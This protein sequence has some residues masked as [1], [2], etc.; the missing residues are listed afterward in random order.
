MS[1]TRCSASSF[2]VSITM[3]LLFLSCCMVSHA[4]GTLASEILEETGVK[5]GLVIHLGC[6]DGRL[7]ANLR[8]GD[9]YLV[10]GLDSNEKN[11]QQARKHIGAL[12]LYGPVSVSAFDGE[13]LPHIDNVANLVVAEDL[14]AVPMDEVLR[15]LAPL[16]V[17][18]I[19]SNGKWTKTTKP[20]PKDI[21]EWTHYLHGPDNNAVANDTVVAPPTGLQWVGG[22]LWSRAHS[23]L[24]GTSCMVSSGGRIFTIED[25]APIAFPLM[26]GKYTLVARDA[27]NG[28]VLWSR[29]LENWDNITH[30]MKPNPV[31]LPRRLVAVGGRV[32]ATLGIF[33]PVTAMDA[34][35]GE[36][37][38]VYKGTENTQEIIVQDDVL[39]VVTGDPMNPYGLAGKRTN[40]RPQYQ[41]Y[42]EKH[43]SPLRD[44]KQD[45]QFAVL[46]V[47]SKTGALLWKKTGRDSG[48]YEAM[49]LAVNDGMLVYQTKT[50]LVRLGLADGKEI[51]TKAAPTRM[52]ARS[53]IPSING[54]S[55]T[56]VLADDVI[57]RAG[58]DN[59]IAFSASDGKEMWRRPTSTT[60][61]SPPDIFVAKGIVW[62]YPSTDGYDLQTGEVAASR[63]ITRDGP[64]GH[65]RCHRNKAT[66]RYMINSRSG[67]ADFSEFDADF[68]LANPWI[69]GTCS[70]GIMPCNG[71]LY[72][73]PH[74]C[75]C[76]NE[77]KLNGFYALSDTGYDYVEENILVKGPAYKS[78]SKPGV[79]NP[80]KEWPTYRQNSARTGKAGTRLPADLEP[81]WKV[82]IPNPTAPVIASK[83]VLVANKDAHT[84]YSLNSVNGKTA[85]TFTAGGRIDSPPTNAGGRVLF[86]SADGWVYCLNA[87]T[88]ELA[89]KFRAAPNDRVTVAFG[90][91]ESLWPVH[92]SVL[93]LDDTAYVVAG[94]QSFINGGL[95]LTGIDIA[96]GSKKYETR[97][98]G[99]YGEDGESV[100]D[101][102]EGVTAES[103]VRVARQIKGNMSD[104][105]L[106]DGETIYLRHMAFTCELTPVERKEHMMTVSGFLDGSGHHRSYW[107]VAKGLIYD[108]TLGN[109]VDADLLV[110]EGQELFGTRIRRSNRSPE[111]KNGPERGYALFAMTRAEKQQAKTPP[112]KPAAKKKQT[113]KAA[114][115]ARRQ[116][117]SSYSGIWETGIPVIGKAMLKAGD[118][119]FIA[120]DPGVF[121][122]NDIFRAVEGRAGG[123]LITA[124]A[125]DGKTLNEY[126]L[127]S[128]PVWDGMA[129][130]NNR[131]FIAMTDGQVQCWG[132][133][134]Q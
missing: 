60:Y 2:R 69:R 17:A 72:G 128:P 108:T 129:A 116:P 74:A 20:W 71:L 12:G 70:L 133:P 118:S 105:L 62:S 44:P 67:G 13:R 111:N 41:V 23:T 31:Q 35:T 77:V 97:I 36:V 32:Y 119:L 120:G 82:K 14:G 21:D 50:E 106:S 47:D 85:W 104:I 125:Q 30:W 117:K 43:Y 84:L 51:W 46:A 78:E 48:E 55:P 98:A 7:T 4:A 124:A 93:V 10:H 122:D 56:L 94:R 6:G 40:Y 18:Y 96:T 87:E 28:V 49:T 123:V 11:V 113:A 81:K 107:T 86:G 42:D 99:P 91:V 3:L 132:K 131:L 39:Y 68:S 73:S 57:L 76:V 52:E 83:R 130:A 22:P 89:W 79:G 26:P 90:Q 101:L 59:L 38:K 88:G 64:M 102:P 25:L 58:T 134:S 45:P 121:P 92:G 29:P 53:S 75:S 126:R 34:A 9:G 8:A 95:Y 33:A 114:A 27:F 127:D 1:K 16:G 66:I 112:R 115:N 19:K 63:R 5:G 61:F 54:S 103:G 109:N 15:V 110:M 65:D 80:Q 24:N 37:I 100:F